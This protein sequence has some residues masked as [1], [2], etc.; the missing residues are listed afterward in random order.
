MLEKDLA[1]L[2]HALNG[3]RIDNAMA[4]GRLAYAEH[5]VETLLQNL[6]DEATR[7]ELIQKREAIQAA[8]HARIP[9]QRILLLLLFLLLGAAAFAAGLLGLFQ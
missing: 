8:R 9:R 1:Q 2:Q 7:N 3:H 4:R 5:L 6:P